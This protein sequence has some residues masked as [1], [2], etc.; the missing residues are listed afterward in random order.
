MITS[1]V[2]S[3]QVSL[4]RVHQIL[5]Q[6]LSH[7][8]MVTLHNITHFHSVLLR[9]V[10][11]C[12][13]IRLLYNQLC[14]QGCKSKGPSHGLICS[15][16]MGSMGKHYQIYGQIKLQV[17]P[18]PQWPHTEFYAHVNTT[19]QQQLCFTHKDKTSCGGSSQ[20]DVKISKVQI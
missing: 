11:L 4:A 14:N 12:M 20:I 9:W 5:H 7:C 13:Y 19:F 15:D 2:L 6:I 17:W 1:T 18:R 10:M 8:A 16:L 3:V